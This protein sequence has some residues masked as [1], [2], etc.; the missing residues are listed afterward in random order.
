MVRTRVAVVSVA[1]L[2]VVGGFVA[3][4]RAD[5]ANVPPGVDPKLWQQL[6]PNLGIALRTERGQT[7]PQKFYGTL[8]FKDGESWRRVVLEE[9]PPGVVPAR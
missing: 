1:V 4:T 7:G 3:G 9:E 5:T 6:S 8:M 2:L